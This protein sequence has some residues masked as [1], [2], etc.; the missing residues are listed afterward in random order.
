MLQS[1][2]EDEI[3]NTQLWLVFGDLCQPQLSWKV[4]I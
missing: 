2:H 4:Q 1:F 3:P